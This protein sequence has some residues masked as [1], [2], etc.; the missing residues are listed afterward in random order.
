[1]NNEYLCL[2]SDTGD[3]DKGGESSDNTGVIAGVIIAVVVL[4]SLG[5]VG[6]IKRDL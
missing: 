6:F 4:A 2:F 5:V 1:M 3:G